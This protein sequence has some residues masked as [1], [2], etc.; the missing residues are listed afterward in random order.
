MNL[1][2][3]ISQLTSNSVVSNIK[4]GSLYN[5]YT[6]SDIR[7]IC[8]NGWHVPTKNECTTLSD[9]ASPN[10]GNKIKE[11][12][13]NY[14]NSYS[15]NTN[16]LK[17][18]GRGNGYRFAGVFYQIKD[19]GIIWTSTE[20][21]GDFWFLKLDEYSDI[22][23]NQALEVRSG[24]SIRLI[25]D[26]TTLSDGQS[27]I[28]V[29]N[30]GTVYRTICIGTQEWLADNLAETKYRNGEDIPTV[31]DNSEWSSLSTGARCA[32]DNDESNVFL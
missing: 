17:F 29:G 21:H 13:E 11:A 10:A 28:Y 24:C 25:K 6:I 9:F 26:L 1:Y 7:N 4:Y 12:D 19:V 27:G 8:A 2:L 22:L 23:L 5:F 3:G 20:F 16:S 18:N 15:E 30:D 31:T 32:Y 14:W